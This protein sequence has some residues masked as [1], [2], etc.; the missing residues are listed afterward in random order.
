MQK[1]SFVFAAALAGLLAAGCSKGNEA[2]KAE[3]KPAEA[4]VKCEGVN[5]CAGHGG[6]AGAGHECAGKNGC[7]GQG[8]VET[9]SADECTT[10][11]GKVM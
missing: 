8:W 9:A 2:A 11:G 10:K 7:K 6:C 3:P 5:S 1:S 4:K